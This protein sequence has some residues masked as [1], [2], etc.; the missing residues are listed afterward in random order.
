M[1]GGSENDIGLEVD[2]TITEKISSYNHI[3]LSINQPFT[4]YSY[5]NY[6]W[7]KGRSVENLFY[8]FILFSYDRPCVYYNIIVILA[9][10]I[11]NNIK[12]WS[13]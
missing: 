1:I 4:I 6:R 12:N 8:F 2:G 5:I 10:I 13:W 3:L 11:M 9:L 7:N